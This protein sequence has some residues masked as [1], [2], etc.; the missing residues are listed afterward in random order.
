MQ[1]ANMIYFCRMWFTLSVLQPIRR[2]PML[3]KSL[4]SISI[5]GTSRLASFLVF[6]FVCVFPFDFSYTIYLKIVLIYVLF[7]AITISFH[8]FLSGRHSRQVFFQSINIII[9][10]YSLLF[11]FTDVLS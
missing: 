9:V 1:T 10:L 4:L 3:F 5:A 11:I 7:L 8:N 2:Y 6:S